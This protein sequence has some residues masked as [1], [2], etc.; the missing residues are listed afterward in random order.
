MARIQGTRPTGR[1]SIKQVAGFTF[2]KSS[3]L[4][5]KYA[6]ML[7]ASTLSKNEARS[8][9]YFKILTFD[10]ECVGDFLYGRN[11]CTTCQPVPRPVAVAETKRFR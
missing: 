6:G 4:N 7:I 8:V 10:N 9:Q 3:K 1:Q 2:G 5:D 11:P